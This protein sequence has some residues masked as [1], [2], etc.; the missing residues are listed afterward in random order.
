[1]RET[2]KEKCSRVPLIC[3][4]DCLWFCSKNRISILSLCVF[5]VYFDFLHSAPFW[6]VFAC[7]FYCLLSS[8]LAVVV[9]FSFLF[10]ARDK[11]F[12][13]FCCG[14]EIG[15]GTKHAQK[16]R[17]TKG[18]IMFLHN[19]KFKSWKNSWSRCCPT[20]VVLSAMDINLHTRIW[21]GKVTANPTTPSFT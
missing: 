1:M 14:A 16:R 12:N 20:H 5:D 10:V 19:L 17:K 18:E 4:H 13:N 11:S 7:I 6:V 9:V 8:D 15:C 2:K 21:N 3:T